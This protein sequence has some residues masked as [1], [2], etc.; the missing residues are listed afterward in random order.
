M[1]I[2]EV[3][4]CMLNRTNND[5]L[6]N[7]LSFSLMQLGFIWT[8]KCNKGSILLCRAINSSMM[9]KG[10]FDCET[11]QEIEFVQNFHLI[12]NLHSQETANDFRVTVTCLLLA[13]K[14]SFLFKL[15]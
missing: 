2:L 9:H 7:K 12:F 1:S 10:R 8:L 11:I 15:L 13:R 6:I 3:V 14:L 4:I 5:D